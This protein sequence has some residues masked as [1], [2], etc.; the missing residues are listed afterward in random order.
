MNGSWKFRL[1]GWASRTGDTPPTD[2]EANFFLITNFSVLFS[3][4]GG[5][6][7]VHR[8]TQSQTRLKQLG[9][10]V[11]P[12]EQNLKDELS[13]WMELILG[14]V[15]FIFWSDLKLSL[16]LI[17]MGRGH[18]WPRHEVTKHLCNL[19]AFG[20]AITCPEK[21]RLWAP[22]NCSHRALWWKQ[23]ENGAA[24]SVQ[25]IV[26]TLGKGNNDVRALTLYF[27]VPVGTLHVSW[28]P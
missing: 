13:G 23:E 20:L 17:P 24:C 5:K 16:T 12:E 27:K 2:G 18:W 22:S 9:T 25:S 11:V 26:E 21:V 4:I 28:V 10:Y 7:T 14:S 1:S 19:L 3:F 6:S 8:V 15:E